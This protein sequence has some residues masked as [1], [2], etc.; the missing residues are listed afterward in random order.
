M[1]TILLFL[2]VATFEVAAV[3]YLVHA[4]AGTRWFRRGFASTSFRTINH[5]QRR[6]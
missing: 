3:L 1:T 5:R 2:V 6:S 4:I